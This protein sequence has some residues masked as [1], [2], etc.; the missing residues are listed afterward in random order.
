MLPTTP[1]QLS[2]GRDTVSCVKI[3]RSHCGHFLQVGPPAPVLPSHAAR[4]ACKLAEGEGSLAIFST[5][6]P[7]AA[8]CSLPR[9]PTLLALPFSSCCSPPHLSSPQV[10][11]HVFARTTLYGFCHFPAKY[12]PKGDI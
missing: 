8:N 2:E 9:V 3:E 11:K 5:L 6:G 4:P 12:L 1:C 10:L 7:A